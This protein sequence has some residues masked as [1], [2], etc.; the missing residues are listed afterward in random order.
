MS[1]TERIWNSVQSRWERAHGFTRPSKRS[2]KGFASVS[3][4]PPKRPTGAPPE[5]NK[6]VPL[7]KE[8]PLA[9]KRDKGVGISFGL[10]DDDLVIRKPDGSIERV[11]PDDSR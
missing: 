8:G 5:R 2:R 6:P 11:K 1:I 7:R 4:A 3:C 9:P 10:E